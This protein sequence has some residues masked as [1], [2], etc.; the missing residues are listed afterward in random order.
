[1]KSRLQLWTAFFV[2]ITPVWAGI[3][4]FNG[5]WTLRPEADA[6]SRAWWL[7]IQGAGTAQLKGRFVGFPGGDMNDIPA[8]AIK[9]EYLTFTWDK[10]GRR[11]DYRLKLQGK[12]LVGD[13]TDN[14]KRNGLS[15]A[16]AAE[17]K[18][19]DDGSRK[20]GKPV[21]LFDGKD[22]SRF[23]A[24]EQGKPLGWEVK[25]GLLVNQ[26][27]ANNLQSG[28][29]FWNFILDAEYRLKPDSNSGIGLR[30]RYEVQLLEDYGKVQDTHSHGAIY[31]RIAPSVNASKPAG[32][33][34]Q[35]RVRLVG[36]YATVILNGKTVV[37]KG[38]VEGL[39]AIATDADEGAPG[40]ITLQGDHRI[41]E[42]RKVVVTPLTR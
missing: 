6:R 15:G 34:N 1:M 10:N 30:A 25:D 29:K 7:E 14:G 18:D 42:F 38:L 5:R 20:P 33:W 8:P 16:R 32:E 13:Y 23:S 17:I 3:E 36:R 9:G 40:P 19:R 12:A 22:L 4:E 27:G 26:V 2:M 24:V 21:V 31:S 39:T 35:M 37:D 28:D 41:V 11:I